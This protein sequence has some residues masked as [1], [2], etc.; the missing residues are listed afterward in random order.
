MSA[1]VKKEFRQ[2][3]VILLITGILSIGFASYVE[4]VVLPDQFITL[5]RA[6]EINY[7]FEAHERGEIELTDKEL[8][9]LIREYQK[10]VK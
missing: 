4:F 7:L 1:Q 3:F 2:G 10:P 6:Q 9:K 8:T 5:D